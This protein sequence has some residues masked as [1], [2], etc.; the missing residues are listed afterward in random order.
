MLAE[1]KC[2]ACRGLG[3][4]WIERRYFQV[5]TDFACKIVSKG[6]DMEMLKTY[7]PRST[8]MKRAKLVYLLLRLD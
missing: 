5:R 2:P 8:L 1:H 3:W 4:G 7:A 6:K